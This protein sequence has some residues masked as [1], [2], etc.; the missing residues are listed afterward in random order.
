MRL[1]RFLALAILLSTTSCASS[2]LPTA[3]DGEAFFQVSVPPGFALGVVFRVLPSEA[4]VA[5][6]GGVDGDPPFSVDRL[7]NG[8]VR[9]IAAGGLPP[10]FALRLQ[11]NPEIDEKAEVLPLLV[12]LLNGDTA[13]PVGVTVLP[14][15]P[16]TLAV[17][18][19][20]TPS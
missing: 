17:P 6:A 5:A 3:R 9:V 7:S 16:P 8:T 14:T 12:V 1:F 19:P 4:T 10:R 20:D 13:P 18:D 2:T 15:D 11:W